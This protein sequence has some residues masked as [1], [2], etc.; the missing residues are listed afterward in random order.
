[1]S[2]AIKFCGLTRPLDAEYAGELGAAFAGVIFAEGPRRLGPALGRAV[3][4]AAGPGVSRVGVFGVQPVAEIASAA[5]G[6][7]LD[8]VQ[9]H[10]GTDEA[11]SARV[12]Q[13]TGL[14][15]WAVLRIG[16]GF[17]PE[18]LSDAGRGADGLV[19]DTAAPGRLGGTGIQFDW[20][21]ISSLN[22]QPR[23]L[24]LIVAGGLT[25]EN[26]GEA[27]ACSA[28]D[29]VDVSSGVESSPGVKDHRRMRA[30]ADAVRMTATGR[31]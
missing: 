19:L 13:A 17:A 4:D 10:G 23:A 21:L 14:Q 1:M 11:F 16:P 7:R 31:R 12:R 3:L 6:A 29:V 15:I 27:I 2:A 9:L 24:P 22:G 28:P 20:R 30:F 25:P 8:I 26:V 18:R 5:A